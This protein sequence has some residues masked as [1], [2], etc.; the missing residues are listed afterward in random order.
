MSSFFG[1]LF[2]ADNFMPHGHCFLWQPSTLWLNVGSDA[3]I[4]ASYFAIPV[5]LYY[6]VRHRKAEIPYFWVPLM[7]AAFILLCGTTHVMEIVTVWNPQ[8]RAAGALKL[9]TGVVSFATLLSLVWIMPRAMLLQTPRQLQ[10]EVAAR[11]AELAAVNAQ[12]RTE[13]AARAAAEQQL[14]A[15]DRRKDEFLATLAHELRNPLAP[16]RHSLKLLDVDGIDESKR[17][18]G[19]KVIARQVHRMSLLLDDLMDVSRITRSRLELKIESVDLGSLIAS[20]VETAS[21]LIE[22]KKHTFQVGLP[23][24]PVAVEVDPLRIS[25]AVANLLTNAA[26]YT[27]PGGHISLIVKVEPMELTITVKDTGIGFESAAIP[28]MFEMFT[29]VAAAEQP[30]RGLGIG[31]ALVKG[32]IALHGGTVDARSAGV[33][34]GSEFTI[35]LPGSIVIGGQAKSALNPSS[36]PVP[37]GARCKVIVVDDNRDSADALALVL[38]ADGYEVKTGYSGNEALTLAG[39]VHPHAV[40]LDIGM[41]DLTGY[42][43]ARRLRQEAWGRDVLLVAMTGWGQAKDKESAAAA[44]FDRHFTKPL[45]PGELQRVLAEFIEKNSLDLR[46]NTR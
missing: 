15:A 31:L 28:D 21:P 18:W 34:Q 35:H 5:A 23:K 14:R 12:L 3:L 42:E 2:S 22:E 46:P 36:L 45:D 26:K 1:W 24:E 40:I 27:N 17:Q 37:N 10:A 43:V 9:L 25:Q 33:G 38:E 19:S 20:A 29:Q 7:F 30:E 6:F 4:A 11:T 16:I 8:Y 13:I 32:L 41:P 39:Q 44:G